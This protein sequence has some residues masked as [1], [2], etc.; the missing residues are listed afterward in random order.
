MFSSY[1]KI[2]LRI[3]RKNKLYS[4]VNIAGLTIGIAACLLIG[5]YV[6]NEV[7][8][9]KFHQ[10]A[11]RIVR[12]STEYQRSGTHGETSMTGTK[13][14]PEMKRLFP[15]VS[16]YVRTIK[17]GMSLANGPIAFDEKNVF[18]ADADFFKVFS[19]N[20]LQGNKE[21][22]LDAPQKI[23]LTRKAANKYFGKDDPIGKTLRIN[24][25]TRDYQVTGVVEEAPLNSQIQYD[26][27]IS[28]ASL[29]AFKTEKWSEANYITYLMLSDGNHLPALQSQI[30][31]HMQKIG[32]TELNIQ[33]GS[34]DF[35]TMN[36]QPLTKVHLY[37]KLADGFEPNGNITYIYVLCVVALLILLIACVNYTNLATAQSSTRGTEIGVRKVM[38]AGK[39]QLLRQ[40][41]SESF[42]IS[43]VAMV[44]SVFVSIL[45]LPLFNAITGKEFTASVFFNPMIII[46]SFLLCCFIALLA[47]I[48]P[49][50][51]LSNT[52]LVN[53]L[54][55]G[56]RVTSS[57]SG[58]RKSLITLQFVI[59]I[60]L[61]AATM[62]VVQQVYYIQHKNLGYSREQVVVMPIDYK[63]KAAYSSFKDAIRQLP[64]VISVTGSYEDPTSIGWG[65]GIST[66]DATTGKK[67]LSLNATPV[68][69][70]YLKTMGME[71]AAGRDFVKSDFLLQDTSNDYKNFQAS[72]IINEKAAKDLSWTAEEAIGKVISRGSP[73]PIVGVVKDFHFESLHNPIGPLL[74]FLDTT[75]VQQLFVKIKN[76][77]TATTLAGLES[78]WKSRITHRP[79]DYHFLDED[80]NALYKV[81]SRIVQLFTLFSGLAIL[82]AC[83]GLFALVAFTTIQRSKEIGIRKILGANVGS[84]TMLIARQ[85]LT[86]VVIA[87]VIAIPL[88]WWA[89]SSWLQDFSYRIN[90]SWW[91][92]GL[93]SVLAVVI[94][95]ATVSFHTIRAALVNPVKSLRTE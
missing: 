75:Q 19:F 11:D 91:V 42:V 74:I 35:M 15:Q 67:E 71:L 61:V 43:F 8:Y 59:A 79:F 73:G 46:A 69:L 28:F 6:W 50:F 27:I 80:F 30:K 13:A 24:G 95:M 89:G 3:L 34:S 38:G 39:Y 29:N 81:E 78:I 41:L 10:N 53:I 93:A 7:T 26:V 9:D 20:L 54:K 65:D 55:S 72:Y 51:V 5:I 84:I 25:G 86:L 21:T 45:L 2:A 56:L 48:Y 85:F 88:A 52:R 49:A 70:D 94:A 40:L 12:M 57:G 77:N 82:L 68:D 16:A 47:G 44:L 14:G 37:S 87:I 33:P 31:E 17:W 36:L 62:I 23:V 4:S 90:V 58:V 92:M 1:F 66:E 63:S 76:E 60:F 22:A 18:Y 83:L 32:S 64:N